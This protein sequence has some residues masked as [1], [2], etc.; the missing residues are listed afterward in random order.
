MSLPDVLS[1]YSVVQ[2]GVDNVEKL[3]AT[4]AK[5]VGPQKWLLLSQDH[6]PKVHMVVS[7]VLLGHNIS[8]GTNCLL[9]STLAENFPVEV[10]T[11]YARTDDDA[12]GAHFSIKKWAPIYE[13]LGKNPPPYFNHLPHPVA[14]ITVTGLGSMIL[15][16]SW[17]N[18]VTWSH[19]TMGRMVLDLSNNAADLAR[20]CS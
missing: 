1:D 4:I 16:F 17:N 13:A 9:T 18:P 19:K 10:C 2:Q 7:T 20:Q 6:Q 15:R 11:S 14:S 3:L 5:V 8:T 12:A